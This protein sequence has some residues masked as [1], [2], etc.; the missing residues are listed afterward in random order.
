MLVL[1]SYLI[2]NVSKIDGQSEGRWNN[3]RPEL[4]QNDRRSASAQLPPRLQA[5]LF[6]PRDA[7]LT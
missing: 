4:D 5:P 7:E 3:R 1:I 2:F 6:S